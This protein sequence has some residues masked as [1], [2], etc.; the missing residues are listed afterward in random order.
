M[1]ESGRLKL[2]G[3]RIKEIRK[4]K[5]MTQ[6]DLAKAANMAASNVSELENG[7]TQIQLLTLMNIIEGLQVSADDVLRPNVPSVRSLYQ[8]EYDE[9]LSDCTPQEMEAI[10]KIARELKETLRSKREK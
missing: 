1:D 9:I 7:K 10:I 3:Q 8:G 5:G 6:A 2:V 4:S